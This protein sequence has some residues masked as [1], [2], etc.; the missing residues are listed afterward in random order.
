MPAQLSAR[1]TS[2]R[3]PARRAL[4]ILVAMVAA[5]GGGLVWAVLAV[6][7]AARQP[8][9]WGGGVTAVALCGAVT[10]AV[11]YAAAA[12]QWRHRSARIYQN[13]GRLES[14][15][16]Y[17]L[18]HSLPG[19]LKQLHDGVPAETALGSVT[20]PT[21][22][23]LAL[24][25][26]TVAREIASG[27]QRSSAALAVREA[28][29]ADVTRMVEDSV[30][31]LVRQLRAGVAVETALA[32][33]ARPYTSMLVRLL[34]TVADEIGA[35]ERRTAAAMAACASAAARVQAQTTRM[36]AELRELEDRYSEEKVF[37]DLLS[38]DHRISQMDRVADSVALLSGGRSGRRWT[39]PI[40]MESILRGAMSRV[41]AYRRVRVHTTTS[42]SV[43]GYA[44]EGV[45][46]ALAEILD[47]A[48]SFSAH[49]NQVHVYVEE[50]DA[51]VV[52]TVEDSGLGMRK[53]ERQRAEWLVSSSLDL[54]TL[55]GSRLGLAVV[56]RLATKYGLTVSFRPSSRGGTGTVIMIPRQLITQARPDSPPGIAM[57][58]ATAGPA[59]LGSLTGPDAVAEADRPAGPHEE[60]ATSGQ[61]DSQPRLPKR[62]RGQ[63]LAAAARS[64]SASPEASGPG[65]A[66][67][68]EDRLAAFRQA[69]D[70]GRSQA[71][72]APPAEDARSARTPE[73]GWEAEGPAAPD[74]R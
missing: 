58:E 27:Q 6:P 57:D 24:L 34:R 56:G 31:A 55:P 39:K 9:A 41:E 68:P 54:S 37:A 49:G 32:S 38:L 7:A 13:A 25:V 8:L 23:S 35:G 4:L 12:F 19:L 14:E 72:P 29:D 18:G 16:E 67:R 26:Q 65:P 63:M 74:K 21:D 46:H 48:A 60:L 42:A 71:R 62:P 36:L 64:M 51:G 45:M 11:Y 20:L 28:M 2:K 30:P 3:S 40:G 73:S 5:T 50:E 10:A 70:R 15:L 44:A 1:E 33:V 17:L 52:V 61:P 47:N 66:G 43:A 59:D 22:S 69:T 53:R